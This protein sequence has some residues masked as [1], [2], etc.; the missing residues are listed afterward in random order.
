MS[1]VDLWKDCGVGSDSQ[2][3]G[4]NGSHGEAGILEEHLE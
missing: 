4:G 2:R 1:A 3:Q